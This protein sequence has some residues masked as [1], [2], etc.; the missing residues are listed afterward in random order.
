MIKG[1]KA[2]LRFL[3]RKGHSFDKIR[4]LVKCS[5]STIKKYMKVFSPKEPI[6][7]YQ[8]DSMIGD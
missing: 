2:M 5:D 8:A 6:S 3:C 1:E 7:E 4:S